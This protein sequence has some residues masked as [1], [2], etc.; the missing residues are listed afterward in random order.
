MAVKFLDWYVKIAVFSALVGGSMELFMIKTGF[1][2]I[3]SKKE[4]IVLPLLSCSWNM[5]L[6]I[7]PDASAPRPSLSWN[8]FGTS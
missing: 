6:K 2:M 5:K 8:E 3:K 7:T 4:I 1:C